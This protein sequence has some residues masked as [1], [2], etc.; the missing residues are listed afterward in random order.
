MVENA[1][2]VKDTGHMAGV[3][4]VAGER[5]WSRS[6]DEAVI[7]GTRPERGRWPERKRYLMLSPALRLL[8]SPARKIELKSFYAI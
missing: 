3:R 5:V 8:P 4:E 7:L 1:G 6:K 2:G